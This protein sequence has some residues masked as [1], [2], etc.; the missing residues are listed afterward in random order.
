MY[1]SRQDSSGKNPF[2]V[3]LRIGYDSILVFYL[4]SYLFVRDLP[5]QGNQLGK[6]LC[7]KIKNPR[8]AGNLGP[9]LA[10]QAPCRWGVRRRP[11]RRVSRG[12]RGGVRGW[13]RVGLR[14]TSCWRIKLIYWFVGLFTCENP[15]ILVSTFLNRTKAASM[16]RW[17]ACG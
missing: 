13:C 4:F 15:E 8:K 9:Y 1:A 17:Q 14:T 16:Y 7:G 12:D 10:G 3:V 5:V 11:N 2:F 6:S